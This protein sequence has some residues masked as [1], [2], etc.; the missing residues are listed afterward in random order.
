MQTVTFVRDLAIVMFVAGMTAF[1][2]EKLRQ[3]KVVGYIL[4][5]LIVGP[6]T[7]P[8]SLVSDEA[9]IKILGDLGVIILMF[10]LGLEFNLR[11]LR[12]VGPVAF[13]TATLDVVVM[14]GLGFLLGQA[15]G[16]NVI[17]SL[18]MGAVICDSSSVI[19]TK[20]LTDMGK[21][22]EKFAEV[23]VAVTIVEDLLAI[24]VI[25]L[26]NGLATTGSVQTGAMFLRLGGLLVFLVAV[27]VVGLLII[28]RLIEYLGRFRNNEEVL[29]VAILGICFGIALIAVNCDFSLALGAFLMGIV[30]AEARQVHR[31]E[32]LISPIKH[33]FSAIFFVSVGLM[34]QPMMIGQYWLP[35]LAVTAVVVIGKFLNCSLGSFVAG[36]DGATSLKVGVG[37]AQI[38]EFAYIIAAMGL[39]LK[40]TDPS[41]YQIAVAV[42]VL[43]TVVSP[44]LLRNSDGLVAAVG[45]L[46]PPRLA[47]SLNLYTAWMNRVN[48]G[49]SRRDLV[50]N[51]IVRKTVLT[52]VVNVMLIAA[53]FIVA[54][55]VATNYPIFNE[56]KKYLYWLIAVLLCL[57]LYVATI[58]KL[59]ALGMI[60]S[61][62][63]VATSRK[64][65]LTSGLRSFIANL[66]LGAGVIALA[67]MTVA[68]SATLLPS[69]HVL[70]ILLL[71]VVGITVAGWGHLIKLYTRVQIFL[72]DIL[73]KPPDMGKSPALPDLLHSVS[74]IGFR[75]VLILPKSPVAGRPLKDIQL[76]TVTGAC[77]VGVERGEEKVVNPNADLQL[78]SGDRVILMGTREQIKAAVDYLQGQL[79]EEE[80]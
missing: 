31:L 34:L 23:T 69:W 40:V 73:S 63:L 78:M 56:D 2:F 25:A 35:I 60:V 1:I 19:L 32:M 74:N 42:S 4:A 44:Y 9:S 49:S 16:W 20:I 29:L 7:P 15:M 59:W 53:V 27:V 50:V 75:T 47:S 41:L 26:L 12:K 58:R 62:M 55:V 52:I 43:T 8:F 3:P 76:R 61:E 67:L 57:P 6:Y 70:G 64:S 45:Y 5:G 14:V 30:A 21:I 80:D 38:G 33:M 24:L 72:R 17:S 39:A 22:R 54:G 79:V 10:T 77:A 71:I 68:L 51:R 46:T 11:R 48:T 36:K 66:F 13:I 65:A 37:M 18:F 28:P